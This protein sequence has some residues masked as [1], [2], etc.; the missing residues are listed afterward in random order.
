M[1]QYEIVIRGALLIDGTSS[2]SRRADVAVSDDRIAR[3]GSVAGRGAV[4]VDGRGFLLTPGFVD[5]HAHDDFVALFAPELRFKLLQGVTTEIVGNCGIGAAPRPAAEDWFERLHPDRRLPSYSTYAGY[6]HLLD[7]IGPALNIAVLAG[8]GAMRRAVAPDSRGPLSSVEHKAIRAEL[9]SAL[10][11][12]VVGLSTGLIYEPGL[13]ATHAELL[14]LARRLAEVGGIYATHLRDEGDQLLAAVDEAL[15]LGLQSGVSVQLSHHKAQGRKNWGRVQQSLERV[16]RARQQQDVW[17]DQYPYTAGSTVLEA[18]LRKKGSRG[19]SRLDE[20]LPADVVVS[21]VTGH[22]DLSGRSLEHLMEAW[23][24]TMQD[25]AARVLDLDPGAWVVVFSMSERDVRRVMTHPATL[26][27]SDGLP[28][29]GTPHPRLWGTFP[30][31]L[32]RYVRREQVL[33]IE[34]AVAKM[35]SLPARRFGLLDRGRIEEGLAAD[36]V[37]LDPERIDEGGSY[38]E[39]ERPPLG[40]HSVWVNGRLAV[41]EGICT[42]TRAGRFLPRR[43]RVL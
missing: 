30:R 7:E 42:G 3:V 6:V 4:E 25:A 16:D 22:P 15:E 18:L 32:G 9:D 33:S 23:C 2:D 5:V 26:F 27:G 13:H 41:R 10:D 8:H 19:T 31:V 43:S 37:L 36:L 39:P 17:L 11:A 38:E 21:S 20:M 28:T 14:P 29:T 35:T 24:C 34:T 12:G 1:Q 40:I